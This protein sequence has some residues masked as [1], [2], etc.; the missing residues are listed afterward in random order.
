MRGAWPKAILRLIW[1]GWHEPDPR[2][3]WVSV[4]LVKRCH[5]GAVLIEFVFHIQKVDHIWWLLGR[6]FDSRVSCIDEI[7][8]GQIFSQYGQIQKMSS[9]KR[10]QVL[11]VTV[12]LERIL[13]SSMCMKMIAY[14]GANSVPIAVPEIWRYMCSLNSKDF[15]VR[16]KRVRRMIAWRTSGGTPFDSRNADSAESPFSWGMLGYWFCKRLLKI[17]LQ[18]SKFQSLFSKMKRS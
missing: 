9:L 14:G 4:G 18:N 3:S 7:N 16:T 13:D 15:F 5:N 17:K 1:P 8:E 11:G 12:D 6:E 2:N 10:H